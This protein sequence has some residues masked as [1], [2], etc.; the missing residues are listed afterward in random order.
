METL[1]QS[2]AEA[3]AALEEEQKRSAEHKDR[4]LRTLADMENLRDRMSR[5]MA[6]QKL[7]ATEG[8]LKS[9]VEVADDLERA[10]QSVPEAVLSGEQAVDAEA[11]VRMLRSLRDGVRMTDGILMNVFKKQGVERF[12][13]MGQPFDPDYHAALMEVNDPSKDPKTI[14]IV[15]KKGYK[16]ED[17]ALR[18]ADVGVVAARPA[19]SS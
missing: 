10:T 2:L 4:M 8:L 19:A 17:R 1:Q 12:D 7:H 3:Q 13:P 15:I 11:A 14:A 16:Y 5:Q 9:L 18:A 6:Q